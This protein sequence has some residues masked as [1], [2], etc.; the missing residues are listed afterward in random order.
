[1]GWEV[2]GRASV[3]GG[4]CACVLAS[5]A[6]AVPKGGG[7]GGTLLLLGSLCKHEDEETHLRCSSAGMAIVLARAA[8]N[9]RQ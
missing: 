3:V 6:A 1:V 7:C 4:A 5:G 8:S 2:K 9:S